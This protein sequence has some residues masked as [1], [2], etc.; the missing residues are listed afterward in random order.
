MSKENL[1]IIVTAYNRP[2][3]LANLLTSLNNIRSDRN[4]TLEISIDNN[5]TEKVN[6][7]AFDYKWKFGEK[8]VTV[9]K[10][11]KD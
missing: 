11:K 4:I 5:G 10:E 8:I 7:I 1:A 9:H 2:E 6:Q 3:A